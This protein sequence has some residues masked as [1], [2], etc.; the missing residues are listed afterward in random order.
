MLGNLLTVCNL[1]QEVAVAARPGYKLEH[2]VTEKDKPN[3]IPKRCKD[4]KYTI[5][6][7]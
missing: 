7:K 1:P 5:N 3:D 4:I 6:K 2:P